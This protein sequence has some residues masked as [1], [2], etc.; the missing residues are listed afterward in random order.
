VILTPN[1]APR[2]AW[3]EIGLAFDAPTSSADAELSLE[4][5]QFLRGRARFRGLL[6]EYGVSFVADTGVT[7][8]LT[9]GN[10]D[11]RALVDALSF[12][13]TDATLD[14]GT[15]LSDGPYSVIRELRDFQETDLAVLYRLSHG[16]NFSV[17]GAGKT[18]VAYAL[19]ALEQAHGRVNK[20]LVVA[21]LSAFSAWNDEASEVLL[22]TP[23]VR[24]MNSLTVPNADVV[25][26][27]YQRLASSTE[28]LSDW[29]LANRVHLIVDEAHRAK[30]GARG[31]WGRSLASLAPLAARRDILTGTPAPNHP[32]D[33]V[34][35]LDLLWPGGRASGHVPRAALARDPSR[36][37]MG[38]VHQAISPLFVRTSKDR[39]GLRPA[40]IVQ[41]PIPMES[42][43]QQIYDAMLRRYSGSLDLDRRD[44]AMFGQMGE[45]T[46]YLMQA[47][48]SPRLL[49]T[50]ADPARAYR[51]PSLAIPAGSSLAGMVESYADHE[52]PAKIA[53]AC[54]IVLA[55]AD[56]GRKTLLWSN[57]PDNLLDLE[58]QLAGL[59]PAVVYGA[60]PS[61]DDAEL[62]VRTRERELDRF[63]NDA[64]CMVLL[65][66]PAALSEGVSLHHACNDAV[67]IDRTFNAGQYLQ[68]LDRIHRLGLADDVETN[69][70]LLVSEGT[71][72]ERIH[73]RLEDK[74]QR[75]SQM[76]DDPR[77]VQMALPDDEDTYGFVDDQLDIAEVLMHLREPR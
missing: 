31:E 46:A 38:D 36:A 71:I 58:R 18:T 13:A 64:S 33:L 77:L 49:R 14:L 23:T 30:R 9:R 2:A 10:D 61:D 37:A 72:D 8:L 12:S 11:Q 62:G 57:F 43:Q 69:I 63:R 45:V 55:N 42:L 19:H 53:V 3:Y 32:R 1:G 5:D 70:T 73:R 60:I 51:Y 26:V 39:L 40:L 47:A 6:R 7:A 25:L 29:M 4:L 56:A 28:T 17:P 34:S 68:S 20:L 75:L 27:N 59:N 52:I 65:A 50:S 35:L 66:N 76:L 15:H 24:R 54:R 16:A 67:Y 44:A 48:S 74:I 21:P 22:P 41:H